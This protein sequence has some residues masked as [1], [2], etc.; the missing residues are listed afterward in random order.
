[1]KKKLNINSNDQ[2][3]K[4]QLNHHQPFEIANNLVNF[5]LSDQIKIFSLLEPYKRANVFSY[6]PKNNQLELLRIADDNLIA[7]IINQ[8][9]TDDLR[10][11]LA[12]LENLDLNWIM[13]L[14]SNDKRN[15]MKEL[16][17]YEEEVAASIMSLD[18]IKIKKDLQVK[19]ATNYVIKEMRDQDFIDY[20]FQVDENDTLLGIVSIREL[21][22]AR[23]NDSINDILVDD[24]IYCDTDERI[25]SVIKKVRDYDLKAIPV[26]D[27]EQ[28]LLGII[29]ADDVLLE[30]AYHHEEDYTKFAGVNEFLEDDSTI[31]RTFKRLPWL[32]ISVVLNIVIAMFLSRFE[33]IMAAVIALTFFQPMILGMA[34]NIGTQSLAATILGLNSN[35]LIDKEKTKKHII[36]ELLVSA[37]NSLILA[38]AAFLVV[39]GFLS[40]MPTLDNVPAYL[41]GITVSVSIFV[42]LFFSAVISIF[43]PLFFQ[44]VKIDPAAASGPI[45]TTINDVFSLFVYF[46]IA[47]IILFNYL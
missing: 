25:E 43:I 29:T 10:E 15:Q 13:P 20:I 23:P 41:I 39:F 38:A 18:F 40:I 33:D 3:I 44:K 26:L 17:G 21:I 12:S 8:L 24:F 37:I 30:L 19:E 1:M 32:L 36:K 42:A 46:G 14:L 28:H 6:L 22:I 7:S 5:S 34:G 16:L 47:S 31:K 27:S 35:K 11:F 4:R 9:D 2:A 45:I